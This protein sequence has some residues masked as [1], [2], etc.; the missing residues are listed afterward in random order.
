LYVTADHGM[1]DVAQDETVDADEVGSPLREGVIAIAGEPRMRHVHARPGAA[2]DV[3]TTWRSTLGDRAWVL[4]ADSAI[5]AGL[6]GSVVT[7]AAR[8][9]IGDVVAIAQGRLGIVQRKRESRMSALPGHH[10][11]LTDE[12]LLVPLLSSTI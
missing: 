11:A 7:P 3:L 12:E 2:A 9:R 10:G 6:F 8:A 4:D 5:G 1:T